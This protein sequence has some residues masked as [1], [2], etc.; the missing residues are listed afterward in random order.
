MKSKRIISLL[1]LFAL[2]FTALP[3][4]TITVSAAITEIDRMTKVEATAL[5]AQLKP[6]IKKIE[7]IDEKK[8]T[9]A[10]EKQLLDLYGQLGNANWRLYA[11]AH[12]A[13]WDKK[14]S[15]FTVNGVE[16]PRPRSLWALE[17]YPMAL[18]FYNQG[19]KIK[20][21]YD[22]YLDGIGSDNYLVTVKNNILKITGKN[23]IRDTHAYSVRGK[24]QLFRPDK[25]L[26]AYVDDNGLA[27][28]DSLINPNDNEVFVKNAAV[29]SSNTLI[30]SADLIEDKSAVKDIS[31]EIELSDL[32]DGLYCIKE[33]VYNSAPEVHKAGEYWRDLVIVVHEGKASLQATDI[34]STTPPKAPEGRITYGK[35][36][37]DAHTC[38]GGDIIC[39]HF[40]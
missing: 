23:C 39:T 14:D 19:V 15:T 7:L 1:L 4:N 26:D 3:A 21:T 25:G 33:L 31:Y 34:W 9:A 5:I 16:L 40:Y 36:Y 8:R 20:S 18:I 24:F 12:K 27:Y 22:V 6:K 29:I 30:L 13:E 32:S 35:W 17:D 37:A 10:E 38:S 28:V 11:L 2:L